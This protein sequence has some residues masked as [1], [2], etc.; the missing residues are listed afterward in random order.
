MSFLELEALTKRYGDQAAVD[1]I[2]LAVAKGEFVSLLGPSGCGKTTTLQ[3]IAGFVEPNAGRVTLEGRDLL[4]VPA[5]RRGLGIVFQNYALFPHMTVVENV[6]FG[7]E[8]RKI[9]KA[10][11][12]KRVAETLAL[13]G[14]TG[15][16]ERHPVQLSG[17]QQQRVALARALVIRPGLLL[18]DEPL[19]NLDA[20]L[21]EEMQVELRRIQRAVGI[22]TL[23]VTHDQAEALALSDRVV[24]M[25]QGRIEQEDSPLSAYEHPR[26]G[27]VCDFLG[28]ANLFTVDGVDADGLRVGTLRL[29]LPVG[30][31]AGVRSGDRILVRPEKISFGEPGPGALPARVTNRVFQGN[32]WLV[33]FH[34]PLGDALV[35]R[36]NDGSACPVEGD[37]VHLVWRAEAMRTVAAAGRAD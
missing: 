13:V 16:A 28:K 22:T 3:M 24:V 15:F 17:G 27:F 32:H 8:M 12:Q 7:L 25:N 10:E 14:L 29:P 21:R 18:L 2:S 5:A 30:E 36:P 37:E 33:Q 23:M 35:I 9:G 26:T 20:K 6:A 11:R 4:A 31:S 19:S 34:T 1:G